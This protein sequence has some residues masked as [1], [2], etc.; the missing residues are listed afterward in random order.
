MLVERREQL[1]KALLLNHPEMVEMT[2]DR[3]RNG[4]SITVVMI[5]PAMVPHQVLQT[6]HLFYHHMII[7]DGYEVLLITWFGSI[8][9]L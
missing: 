5:P 6:P 9:V 4:Q 1:R 7:Y 3:T 8:L 2:F